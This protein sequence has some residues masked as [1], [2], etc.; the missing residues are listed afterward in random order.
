[1]KRGHFKKSGG[2]RRAMVVHLIF[3]GFVTHC[4]RWSDDVF[5]TNKPKR[6]G[7]KLCLRSHRSEMAREKS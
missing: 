5:Y 7:C 6:V 4:G 3:Q 1:M 2:L